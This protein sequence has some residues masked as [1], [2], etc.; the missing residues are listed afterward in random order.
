MSDP[1]GVFEVTV[2]NEAL[3][4]VVRGVERTGSLMPRAG[5]PGY[6]SP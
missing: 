5:R 6:R 2:F 4:A 3:A 1:S